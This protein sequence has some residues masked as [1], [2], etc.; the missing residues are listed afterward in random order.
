MLDTYDDPSNYGGSQF[1]IIICAKLVFSIRMAAYY[2][3]RY[4]NGH[5]LD[6]GP[7]YQILCYTASYSLAYY[8]PGV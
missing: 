2:Y 4:F 6:E 8:R 1:A 3:S 7:V 5:I